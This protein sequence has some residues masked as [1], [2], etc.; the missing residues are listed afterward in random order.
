MNIGH[1]RNSAIYEDNLKKYGRGT[2]AITSSLPPDEWKD[3]Y[4]NRPIILGTEEGYFFGES[5]GFEIAQLQP[6]QE[7]A[8]A[9]T[10]K[11][12][13]MVMLGAHIVVANPAN[14]AENTVRL[15][16][17]NKIS[18]LST[19][20]GNV[21]D[22]LEEHLG[23]C[24]DFLGANKDLIEFEMSTDFIEKVAEPLVMA[25]LLAQ[26]TANVIPSSIV[27]DYDKSVGILP[28]D[29]DYDDL[30]S[31]IDKANPIPGTASGLN[32]PGMIL[33][34]KPIVQAPA[35]GVPK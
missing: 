29:V 25:Q 26:F 28:D 19:I 12:D 2:L 27:L 21:E 7:A 24:A 17:G 3:F 10:Q 1:L 31:E 34:G 20:V 8:V 14:I 33:P 15:N 32:K 23:Y 5:G 4:Q 35:K 11:Q 16:M 9:M 22:A 30:Q 6:A 18:M 13:Q